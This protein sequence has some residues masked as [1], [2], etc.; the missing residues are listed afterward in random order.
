MEH[1]WD[2]LNN[3]AGRGKSWRLYTSNL[4]C[5]LQL[6]PVWLLM[7]KTRVSQD[8]APYLLPAQYSYYSVN[9]TLFYTRDLCSFLFLCLI[10]T[11]GPHA[12]CSQF[13]HHTP[14]LVCTPIFLFNLIVFPGLART[15]D[16]S[17]RVETFFVR[18]MSATKVE[19]LF[20]NW[21]I[22]ILNQSSAHIDKTSGV[23]TA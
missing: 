9:Y 3:I 18:V 22:F 15:A 16:E 11:L 1:E 13:F 8:P 14:Y 5:G 7:Q 10:R 6:N 2:A 20:Y 23:H 4:D 12:L 19:W 21:L 17:L